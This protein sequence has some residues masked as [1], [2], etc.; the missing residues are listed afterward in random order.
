VDC[1]WS[2]S[3]CD[4]AFFRLVVCP[5]SYTESVAMFVTR[6]TLITATTTHRDSGFFA[7]S[8]SLMQTIGSVLLPLDSAVGQPGDLTVLLAEDGKFTRTCRM[9][10][11]R[12]KT[13]RN[14]TDW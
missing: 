9:M 14:L 1:V 4:G 10:H 3:D 7:R 11:V 12:T 2:G 5:Y 8:A 13:S 6:S